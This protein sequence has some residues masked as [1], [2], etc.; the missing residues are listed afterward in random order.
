MRK[1][2]L[3]KTFI[4]TLCLSVLFFNQQINAQV[5][6]TTIN[7]GFTKACA[8]EDF[9]S[10]N[11]NFQFTGESSLSASNQF[12][13]EMS[14]PSGTFI[15]PA[16]IVGSSSAG[17]ITTS[18]A[19]LSFQLPEGTAGENYKIRIKSTSPAPT[20]S[21]NSQA[22]AAYYKPQ[23]SP[24]SINNLVSTGVY[25]PGGSYVLRIDNPGT[26]LND[27]P[28]Q[29]DSLTFIWYKETGPTTSVPY[30]DGDG[31]DKTL[32]VSEE[33]TYFVETDYGSC[34]PSD[35]F[36]N[37]VQVSEATS[38]TVD[39]EIVS[40]LGNP[41]CPSEDINGVTILSTL[42]GG[43]DYKWYKDNVLVGTDVT[44]E[45]NESGTY[46]VDIDLG[47]C[48]ASTSIDLVS[49]GPTSSLNVPN[50]NTIQQGDILN[51]IVTT[52]ATDPTFQ[53]FLN[54]NLISGAT[55]DTYD[56][57]EFGDYTVIVSQTTGCVFSNELFFTI[58]EAVDP[59]PEVENI[60]N[61]ISPNGD[62]INDKWILPTE[63]VTGT[64]TE[65]II[66]DSQGKIVHQ[67]NEYLNNW[68]E[69]EMNLTSVNLVY[70][71]IITTE[72]QQTKKGS[73]TLVK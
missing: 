67:T 71:Y 8:S 4:Y 53:W 58:N 68:P 33:G 36:S 25:C 70:Y 18:P 21:I 46:Q 39:T 31:D 64:N 7:L 61:L 69:E 45:A 66:L 72:D 28:L 42:S 35:S 27:S 9:N 23:D 22:F 3:L 11:V 5:S 20:S 41:F 73:I 60:P 10:Y 52:N 30:D 55:S 2:T 19:T 56:A 49:E 38:G 37:R 54:N 40:S 1:T 12:V 32:V 43:I 29:Y 47:G 6:I 14:D 63:Y 34:S 50:S 13:I 59:F 24:F 16:T 65:V 15:N 17:A 26:G 62:A 48:T 57:T 44:Y 51:V